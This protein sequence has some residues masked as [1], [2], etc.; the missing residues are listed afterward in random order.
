[1]TTDRKEQGRI[2]A[3]KRWAA[4]RQ[5]RIDAGLPP[6][7]RPPRAEVAQRRV[8]RLEANVERVRAE[9]TALEAEL[10]DVRGRM[11]P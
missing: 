3:E 4:Y 10:D 11:R 1:M 5:A 2:D 9:L 8:A 7:K 6:T